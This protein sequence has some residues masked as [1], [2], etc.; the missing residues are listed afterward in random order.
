MTIKYKAGYK[1]QLADNYRVQT[2]I[3]GRAISLGPIK[4]TTQGWLTVR[5]GY[6][7]DGPSGPT[8]DTPSFMR[9]SL[10]HDAL[11]QLMRSKKLSAKKYRD[12]ADRLLQQMCIEDGMWKPRAWV[13]YHA[14]RAFGGPSASE[15]NKRP[16]LTAP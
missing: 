11:Y 4:L 9:G 7:W 13:V 6:A 8:I 16:I 5:R 3:K 2:G 1:Y 12:T 10:V 15:K 14:V